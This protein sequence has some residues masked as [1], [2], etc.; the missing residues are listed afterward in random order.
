MTLVPWPQITFKR[1]LLNKCQVRPPRAPSTSPPPPPSEAA[2]D[3]DG[4]AQEEFERADRYDELTDAETLG[5]SQEA[6][7]NKTRKVPAAGWA[8]RR[9]GPSRRG[10]PVRG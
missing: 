4:A 5:L 9:R 1:C 3:K 6:K 8:R 7:R 10:A 2:R